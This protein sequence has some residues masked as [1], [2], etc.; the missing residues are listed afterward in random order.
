MSL[1][2]SLGLN[3]LLTYRAAMDT[4]GHNLANQNT[5][6]YSRQIALLQTGKAAKGPKLQSVG[7]GVTLAGIH[8]TVN[9]SLL[10]RI[11]AEAADLG[12]FAAEAGF[13][14][15]VETLLGDLTETG[16][17]AGLQG[18][19]DAASLVGTTPE[20]A[21][22]RQGFLSSADSL[23]SSF[24]SK[25]SSLTSLRTN[26]LLEAQA[27]VDEANGLLREVAD[28]NGVIKKQSAIGDQANDLRD[29]RSIVLEQLSELVG[30]QEFVLEDG[31][32]NVT[33]GSTTL[34]TGSNANEIQSIATDGN[35]LGFG[36]EPGPV[37][38]KQ[39]GGRL[40]GM[41]D[42]METFLPARLEDLDK[43]ARELIRASNR[44]HSTGVPSTGPFS[45]LLG[46]NAVDAPPLI[47]PT[48]LSLND[49]GLPFEI[50]DGTL[51]IAVTNHK[52]GDVER[53]EIAI[54]PDQMKLADLLAA[55][56][57]VPHLNASLNGAGKLHI[58]ASAGYGFDFSRKVDP[59]PV[60]GGT[61]GS[62]SA[63]AVGDGS[64]PVALTPG[65]QFTVAVDGGAPQ[66]V[67]IN[68]IDFAN[69]AAAT[70]DE[71]AAALNAQ[72]TGATA[73]VVDGRIVLSTG[74]T[75]AASSLAIVDSVGA[76]AAALGLPAAAAGTDV[77]VE[78]T[79]SGTPTGDEGGTYTFAPL[80]DGEIGVTPDLKLGIYDAA[81]V[82]VDTVD[83][84]EGYEPGSPI[85]LVDGVTFQ[86]SP[87][88]VQASANQFFDLEV[89]GPTDTA[90]L[91]VAFGLNA[92]FE[93]S[94]ASTID[95]ADAVKDD[96]KALAGALAGGPGDGDNFLRFAELAD[97]GIPAFDGADLNSRYT[98]FAATVGTE[99][100]DA[101]ASLESSSLLML[102]LQTQ[103][104]AESGVNPDEEILLLDQYQL[105]Y[106]AAAK[107]LSTL[108]EL[109]EALLQ[110]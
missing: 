93:G 102:T 44:V 105:A 91:L 5:P 62:G 61:F 50:V 95:V 47:N 24:R 11:R 48:T 85:T 43:I 66:T 41:V 70:A 81:G 58:Q 106:E 42:V 3:A 1:G 67:T 64:F 68:A 88:T 53:T 9:E 8:S 104:A 36:L 65:D 35:K 109:D 7:T 27:I 87:G 10:F 99:S 57:A 76:P 89:P 79:V 46:A 22:L 30:A 14:G 20:D 37:D 69:P 74:S 72:L 101:Q 28:L 52:T 39:V 96:P 107:F 16:I 21:V 103:R 6:G 92:L 49:L 55:I 97:L 15:E 86:L 19:F 63:T 78:V 100:A 84:G 33:V 40:R 34:V 75:G 45:S 80:S 2:Y 12:R 54:A 60:E 94:D 77:P 51:S 83:V 71:V 90:D 31:T 56:D 59:N 82:L 32:A 26:S 73:S 13:L 23:A 108:S 18:F 4:I 110:L 29:R 17:G 98:S 25:A 38:L